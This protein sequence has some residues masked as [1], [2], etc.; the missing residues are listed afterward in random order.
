[1]FRHFQDWLDRNRIKSLRKAC[2]KAMCK[3]HFNDM[4]D[5]LAF[6]GTD[7]GSGVQ[8]LVSGMNASAIWEPPKTSTQIIADL[9]SAINRLSRRSG[10]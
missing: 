9:T 10:K 1:M 2:M 6:E 4:C 5:K 7:Y 3:E 8:G